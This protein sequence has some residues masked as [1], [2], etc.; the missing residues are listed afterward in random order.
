MI[1]WFLLSKRC[2]RIL[3]CS[4]GV[5]F[6]NFL[7]L[8][9][10]FSLLHHLVEVELLSRVIFFCGII[11]F[12]IHRGAWLTWILKL[13]RVNLDGHYMVVLRSNDV[14]RL[15]EV[16]GHWSN[17]FWLW[18]LFQII[19][20]SIEG[21]PFWVFSA[22]VVAIEI[23]RPFLLLQLNIHHFV[24]ELF[25][26]L[27]ARHWI[28][29][30]WRWLYLRRASFVSSFGWWNSVRLDPRSVLHWIWRYQLLFGWP[31]RTWFCYLL[32]LTLYLI[33]RWH[34]QL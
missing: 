19:V 20:H 2:L 32:F 5:H 1:P 17:G 31:H 22:A 7:H 23:F 30:V 28:S 10:L 25:M 9:P 24:I 33:L 18:I 21:W 26:I 16:F 4:L 13:V 3:D 8:L 6:L 15:H 12:I 14:V 34:L 11:I 29:V 27:L